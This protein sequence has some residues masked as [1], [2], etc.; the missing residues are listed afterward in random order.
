M[1]TEKRILTLMVMVVLV[2]FVNVSATKGRSKKI[3]LGLWQ[4]FKKRKISHPMFSNL[5][6]CE[7]VTTQNFVGKAF[8]M[9]AHV[10]HSTQ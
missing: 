5:V 2:Q 7:E 10:A 8:M 6:T 9:G 4:K 1:T 3:L